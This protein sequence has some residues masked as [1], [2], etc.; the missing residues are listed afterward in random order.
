MLYLES[1]RQKGAFAGDG[2]E[3]NKVMAAER[4]WE[5]FDLG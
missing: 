1:Q 5:R 4:V 3:E 2:A